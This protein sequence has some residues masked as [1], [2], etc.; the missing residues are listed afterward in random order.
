MDSSQLQEVKFKFFFEISKE[1]LNEKSLDSYRVRVMNPKLILDELR[2]VIE[3]FNRNKIQH[4]EPTV[5]DVALEAHELL[6][7]DD[8]LVFMNIRKEIF[9]GL[10]GGG[11]HLLKEEKNKQVLML[12]NILLSQNEDYLHRILEKIKEVLTNN[13]ENTDID[14][15]FREINKLCNILF[16]ELISKKYSRKYLKDLIYKYLRPSKIKNHEDAWSRFQREFNRKTQVYNMY[17]KGRMKTSR[18]FPQIHNNV[19][20]LTKLSRNE[21]FLKEAHKS[22]AYNAS[23]DL[24]FKTQ[25]K[26]FDFIAAFKEGE[27]QLFEYL[28]LL[29]FGFNDTEISIFPK[30]CIKYIPTGIYRIFDRK[31]QLDG[32]YEYIENKFIEFTD[33]L[34][35]L[36]KIDHLKDKIY[37]AIRYL[38]L[39]NISHEVEHKLLNYWIGMEYLFSSQEGK[40]SSIKRIKTFF[41]KMHAVFYLQRLVHYFKATLERYEITDISG[42]TVTFSM[43]DLLSE[44][45]YDKIINHC[46]TTYPFLVFRA[47]WLKSCLFNRKTRKNVLYKHKENICYHLTRIYRLRNEIVH[48]AAVDMNIEMIA[49]NL[50]YYLLFSIERMIWAVHENEFISSVDDIFIYFEALSEHIIDMDLVDIVEWKS[51]DSLIEGI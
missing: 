49:S 11:K 13:S 8:E 16:S 29:N 35:K 41:S 2:L 42:K 12:T 22:F 7:K 25:V 1:L 5:T 27:K 14:T 38:R 30:V 23:T 31:S 48:E 34:D 37:S 20:I 18:K 40:S 4:F 24:F 50:K 28:D 10:L 9:M 26:A 17:V 6:S 33:R 43:N 36:P 21:V 39:G 47:K 19:S 45:S 3:A 51:Y 15:D 44:N 32:G 46:Q